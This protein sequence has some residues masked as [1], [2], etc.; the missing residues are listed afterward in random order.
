[1]GYQ[2]SVEPLTDPDPVRHLTDCDVAIPS[3]LAAQLVYR[4]KWPTRAGVSDDAAHIHDWLDLH[5]VGWR[6]VCY[7][8]RS[9][10]HIFNMADGLSWHL[11][12]KTS[13]EA[14]LYKLRFG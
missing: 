9:F 1:M 12:C 2:P 7:R 11:R 13:N 5:V 10:G 8:R 3:T 14:M 4:Q 6:V